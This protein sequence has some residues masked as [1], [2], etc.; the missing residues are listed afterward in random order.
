[1][2]WSR[3]QLVAYGESNTNNPTVSGAYIATPAIGHHLILMLRYA[4]NARVLDS[5]GDTVSTWQV[6]RSVAA[7][8]IALASCKVTGSLAGKS[9]T[10]T[11][12]GN[13]TAKVFWVYEYSGL[14][15]TA[16]FSSAI[17]GARFFQGTVR[18]MSAASPTVTPTAAGDLIVAG[19]GNTSAETSLTAGSGFTNLTGVTGSGYYNSANAFIEGV[20]GSAPNTTPIEPTATG[21]ASPSGWSCIAGVYI[22]EP[23]ASGTVPLRTLMGVGT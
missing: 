6:D 8:L 7:D 11:L 12:D 15:P 4:N 13:S 22:P 17:S 18:R 23:A 16:W 2:A 1:M 5:V 19:W 9:V 14:H 10:P 20:D 21:G 3:V